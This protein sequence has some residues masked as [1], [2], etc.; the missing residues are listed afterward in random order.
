MMWITNVIL[1]ITAILSTILGFIF[2]MIVMRI[3]QKHF[4]KRQQYLGELNG[5]IEKIY[6]GHSIVKAYNGEEDSINKF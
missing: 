6:T 3:S 5:H 1:T 4:K 2:M